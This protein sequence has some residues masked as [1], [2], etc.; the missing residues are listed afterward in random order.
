MG[1]DTTYTI[2]VEPAQYNAAVR[3]RI[4][5]VSGYGDD[6]TDPDYG[7][8]CK[9]Y[10]HENDM[11]AVSAEF[12]FALI[13]VMGAG[14]EQPD[15][16]CMYCVNGVTE[17]VEAEITYPPMTI[18]SPDTPSYITYFISVFG[19]SVPVKLVY[20]PG[21]NKEATEARARDYLRDYFSA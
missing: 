20:F 21:E 6:V 16:W 3:Q 12:P 11:R 9:W 8:T 5:E 15:L 10:E 2:T 18:P 14:E 7:F 4:A 17:K 19:V 1:Y 13:T